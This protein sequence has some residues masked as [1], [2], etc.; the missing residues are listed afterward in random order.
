MRGRFAPAGTISPVWTPVSTEWPCPCCG[1]T[2]GCGTA[3]EARY[4]H[5]RLIVSSRPIVGGGWLHVALAVPGAQSRAAG[6]PSRVAPPD[7][8]SAIHGPR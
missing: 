4:I 7:A 2:G 1:E 3:D 8:A 6:T 5:C